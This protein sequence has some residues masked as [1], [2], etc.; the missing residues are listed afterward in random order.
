MKKVAGILLFSLFCLYSAGCGREA[1]WEQGGDVKNAKT[2][3][4]AMKADSS[5][6]EAIVFLTKWVDVCNKGDMDTMRNM[7]Y[8]ST[9]EPEKTF[10]D[11]LKRISS[12]LILN[13]VEIIEDNRT[14]IVCRAVISSN[15]DRDNLVVVDFT[16]A[17]TS[18]GTKMSNFKPYKGEYYQA[19]GKEMQAKAK[20]RFGTDN[21]S[22]LLGYANA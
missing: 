14:R 3:M 10:M 9:G 12:N 11:N 21:L 22:Q 20:N 16:L 1:A 5:E 19:L 13:D 4:A 8:L 18:N 15:S 17:K 2:V 6:K 7:I